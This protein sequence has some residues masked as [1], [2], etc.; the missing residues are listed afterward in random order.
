MNVSDKGIAFLSAHEGI[1][2]APYKDSVGVWTYG[3]GHTAGAGEPIP[4]QM[5]RGM[6][7]DIDAEL[8]KVC[9]LFSRDLETYA[10]AVNAAVT[11][12]MQQHE[13]DAALSFHYNTGAIGRATW[14]KQ[15]NAGD[16]NA[17]AKSMMN[18]RSPAGVIPRR[19]EEQELFAFGTYGNKKTTVWMANAAGSV[20]WTPERTLTQD[21]V[22]ELVRGGSKPQAGGTV[23]LFVTLFVGMSALITAAVSALFAGV[24]ALFVKRKG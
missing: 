13:F 22:V 14:V 17:A 2:P 3:I 11:V 16:K 6:P 19:E 21:Q 8:A 7:A 4:A 12:E 23:T 20:V 15:W 1:V 10:S 18:W 24:V 5:P 9:K